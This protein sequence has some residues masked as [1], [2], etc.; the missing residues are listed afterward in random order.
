MSLLHR[1]RYSLP[2]ARMDLALVTLAYAVA[3]YLRFG[4][5]QHLFSPDFVA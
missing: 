4:E 2:L 1:K 5:W 3:Y